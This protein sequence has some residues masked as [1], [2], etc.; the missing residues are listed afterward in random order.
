M[1]ICNVHDQTLLT[2]MCLSLF[3]SKKFLCSMP[4]GLGRGLLSLGYRLEGVGGQ[5]PLKSRGA[6]AY[7]APREYAPAPL[8]AFFRSSLYLLFMNPAVI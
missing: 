6:R 8:S 7:F 4:G 5:L 2:K 3:Q 1:S